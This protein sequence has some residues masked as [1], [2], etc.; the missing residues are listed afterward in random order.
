MG[1]YGDSQEQV[2]SVSRRLR[3]R[4]GY[5]GNYGKA[6]GTYGGSHGVTFDTL[7]PDTAFFGLMGI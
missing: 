6:T 2:F 1:I 4:L 7:K 5:M 3:P